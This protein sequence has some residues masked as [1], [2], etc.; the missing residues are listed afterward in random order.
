MESLVQTLP[1]TCLGARVDLR[2]EGEIDQVAPWL[3][4]DWALCLAA[5]PSEPAVAVVTVP[6]QGTELW[7]R[8][9]LA[10]DV[11]LAAINAAEGRLLMFHAGAVAD[12][13]TGRCFAF[14][15]ASGT[16]KSTLARALGARWS[17]VTDETVG[18][19]QDGSVMPFPKPLLLRA[20]PEDDAKSPVAPAELGLSG[21]PDRPL[22]LVGM[23]V[24]HRDPDHQGAPVLTPLAPP[25]LLMELVPQM[26]HLRA[27]AQPLARVLALAEGLGGVNRVTYAEASDLV[28]LVSIAIGGHP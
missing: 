24:L 23:V 28:D 25:D 9:E 8:S 15:A 22:S 27:F 17:Y 7:Q 13:D 6:G 18:I 5:D 12:P 26:S 19:R 10:Q 2:V 16:G 21:P 20:R 11:T 1:L 14:V 4:Q 3:R